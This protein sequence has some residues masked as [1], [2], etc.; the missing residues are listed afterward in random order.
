MALDGPLA[1]DSRE[2]LARCR[3]RVLS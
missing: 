3:E 1:A 2:P